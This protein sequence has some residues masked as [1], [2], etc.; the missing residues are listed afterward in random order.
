MSTLDRN[1]HLLFWGTTFKLYIYTYNLYL[2]LTFI[3]I[4]VNVKCNK[5]IF[6]WGGND[7]SGLLSAKGGLMMGTK[8]V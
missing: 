7:V 1:M 5:Y 4:N 3:F 6:R 8:K 2:Y